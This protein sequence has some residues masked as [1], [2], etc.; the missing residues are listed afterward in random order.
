MGQVDWHDKSQ[1]L[2]RVTKYAGIKRIFSHT[3]VIGLEIDG[4]VLLAT[5]NWT[6]KDRGKKGI[7]GKKI[8]SCKDW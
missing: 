7:W 4:G 8:E 1:S 2:S 3:S 6:Q 5:E